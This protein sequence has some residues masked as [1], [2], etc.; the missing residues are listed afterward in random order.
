MRDLRTQEITCDVCL[1][2]VTESCI[3]LIIPKPDLQPSKDVH[4]GKC[5]EIAR[6]R[7]P[8]FALRSET[9]PIFSPTSPQF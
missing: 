2:P 8:E 3:V 1:K 6:S 4:K 9:R 7:F 5:E